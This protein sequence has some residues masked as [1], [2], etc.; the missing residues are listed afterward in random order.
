MTTRSIFRVPGLLPWPRMVSGTPMTAASASSDFSHQEHSKECRRAPE[1]ATGQLTCIPRRPRDPICRT[2]RR[3]RGSR[4]EGSFFGSSQPPPVLVPTYAV[5]ATRGERRLHNR[6]PRV[7]IWLVFLHDGEVVDHELRVRP[8]RLADRRS[9]KVDALQQQLA[10]EIL[11]LVESSDCVCVLL[12]N[13]GSGRD[14]QLLASFPSVLSRG[15]NGVRARGV[16]C[17]PPALPP[18]APSKLHSCRFQESH[19]SRRRLTGSLEGSGKHHSGLEVPDDPSCR[20]RLVRCA[21]WTQG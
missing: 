3:Q 18:C 8:S 11:S 21:G 17:C 16:R 4:A 19:V 9:I 2:R 10:Q 1:G 20:A 13:C 6:C 15:E 14:G 7:P 5:A 12:F